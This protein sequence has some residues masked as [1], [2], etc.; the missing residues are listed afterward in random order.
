MTN[1]KTEMPEKFKKKLNNEQKNI[2]CDHG[3]ERPFT[4]KWLYNKDKGF[5]VCVACGN[6]LFSSDAKYDSGTGW[7]SFFKVMNKKSVRLKEDNSMFMKRIEVICN[8]CNGHLG[9]VFPDGPQLTGERYCINSLALD[10][11]KKK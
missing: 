4:G 3:T 8:K 1:K 5:Y 7:P 10:F 11:K 2:I 6:L 9:H